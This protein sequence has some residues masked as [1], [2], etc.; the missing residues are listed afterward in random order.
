MHHIWVVMQ[1]TLHGKT[2]F[3]F[4]YPYYSFIISYFFLVQRPY[5]PVATSSNA[6]YDKANVILLA[7]NVNECHYKNLSSAL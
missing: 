4:Y 7:L 2:G 6:A 5:N 1:A 3:F